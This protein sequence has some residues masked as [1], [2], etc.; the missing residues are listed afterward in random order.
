MEDFSGIIRPVTNYKNSAPE[1]RI[2]T[3]KISFTGEERPGFDFIV[4][5]TSKPQA[6][7]SDLSSPYP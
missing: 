3:A 7:C 6:S 4:N 5:F 2:D 1:R